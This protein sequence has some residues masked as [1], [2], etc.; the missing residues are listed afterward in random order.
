MIYAQHFTQE[1]FREWADDMSARLVTM[2]DVLR[3]RL[4]SA[5]AVSASN[6]RQVRSSRPLQAST[7]PPSNRHQRERRRAIKIIPPLRH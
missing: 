2:L 3:F 6:L 4:G 7:M 1:E 5:I